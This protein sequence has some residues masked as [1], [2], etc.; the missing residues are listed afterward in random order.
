[1]KFYT[2]PNAGPSPSSAP[3]E[4][5]RIYNNGRVMIGL[6]STVYEFQVNGTL[7]A[8]NKFFDIA[9]EGKGGNWRL[10]RGAIESDGLCTQHKRTFDCVQGNSYFELDEVFEWLCTDNVCFTSPVRHFGNSWAECSGRTLQIQ[11]TK[12]GKYN[13]LIFSTRKDICAKECWD[14]LSYEKQQ[15]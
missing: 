11:T 2:H 13:C 14:G 1:M 10:K 8:S 7:A 5:M 12:A 15:N 3:T 6:T 4:R 9:D